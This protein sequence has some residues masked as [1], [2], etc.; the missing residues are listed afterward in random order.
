[1]TTTLA[2]L[3]KCLACGRATPMQGGRT[4]CPCGR[5][6]SHED[7]VVVEIRGPGNVLVPADELTTIDGL[8]WVALPEAPKVVR[9]P[10]A[11]S[12]TVTHARGRA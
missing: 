5:S 11:G 6:T 1:M 9:R 2:P 10:R 4:R 8:P 7:D 12:G 3:L